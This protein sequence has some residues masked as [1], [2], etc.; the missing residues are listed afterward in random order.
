MRCRKG[1]TVTARRRIEGMDVPP[2]PAG[3]PG[4][5]VAT[6]VLGRPKT[7]FFAVS[8]VWGTKRF[9]VTVGP[10]DVT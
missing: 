4:T 9:H 7:V 1:D 10:G 2:V 3:T 8:D 5:V 6:T